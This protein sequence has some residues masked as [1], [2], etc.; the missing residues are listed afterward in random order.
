MS[1]YDAVRAEFHDLQRSG[2]LIE[3]RVD[4]VKV[5]DDG[6]SMQGDDSPAG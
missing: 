2:N 5:I 4:A 3:G 1:E 6:R